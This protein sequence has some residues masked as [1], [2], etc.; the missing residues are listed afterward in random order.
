MGTSGHCGSGRHAF[1]NA[2]SKPN[3]NTYSLACCLRICN[4]NTYGNRDSDGYR[5]R[6]SHSYRYTNSDS[7]GHSNSNS[8]PDTYSASE[9]DHYQGCKVYS[10]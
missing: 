10:V 7:H 2:D 9:S 4:T 1:T 3:A 6:H 5:H 8:N